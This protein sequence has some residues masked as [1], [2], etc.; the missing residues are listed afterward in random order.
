MLN[1]VQK[2]RN[3]QKFALH[4]KF[5][6]R[7]IPKRSKLLFKINKEFKDTEEIKRLFHPPSKA[8]IGDSNKSNI[9]I[10]K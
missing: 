7:N 10:Q 4:Q 6:D 2:L 5:I 1:A 8:I 3:K 9:E